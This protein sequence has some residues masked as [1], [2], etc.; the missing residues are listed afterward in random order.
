M[1][2]LRVVAL[3][4][5]LHLK[6]RSRSA[7]DGVLQLL[8]PL[9]FGT[10]VFLLFQAGSMDET[11]MLSAAI[12]AGVMGVWS[13][14]STTA[15]FALSQERSQGTLELL[16]ASPSPLTAV[17]L[18]I[19]LSMA[20]IG[21]YSLGA[22]MLWGWL[23]FDIDVTIA[24]PVTFA[25]AVVATVIGVGM[26]GFILAL[27]TVRYRA[28]WALGAALELPVWLVCGLLV[29]LSELPGWV[30]PISWL[31][32]PT[33]GMEALRSAALGREAAP[34]LAACFGLAAAYGAIGVLLSGH[35]LRSARIHASLALR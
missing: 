3:G 5:W 15:A 17:I 13:A 30:H 8:W 26:L 24:D 7:F 28:A 6:M 35:L 33:W 23:A 16:V 22:T 1:S 4:W 21:A 31:L 9:F 27:S 2:V 32:A 10:T 11:T 25:V 29:P 18:P 20:T 12:G 19:T 34:A 14:T